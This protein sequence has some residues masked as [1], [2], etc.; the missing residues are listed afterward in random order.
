MIFEFKKIEFA[1]M[2][3][4]VPLFIFS[5]NLRTVKLKNLIQKISFRYFYQLCY[6]IFNFNS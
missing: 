5:H 1:M 2:M 4:N 3:K 6:F